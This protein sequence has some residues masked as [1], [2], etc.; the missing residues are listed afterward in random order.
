[1]PF[2]PSLISMNAHTADPDGSGDAFIGNMIC[3]GVR[4]RRILI[5]A[6]QGSAQG[7][8]EPGRTVSNTCYDW[9]EGTAGT[10]TARSTW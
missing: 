10:T 9:L 1:M 7:S 5:L 4:Q 3:L 2:K 6:D 8:K